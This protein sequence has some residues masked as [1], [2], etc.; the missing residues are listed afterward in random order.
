MLSQ[1]SH[2]IRVQDKPNHPTHAGLAAR[3]AILLCFGI[4]A[5][6]GASYRTDNFVVDAD[7]PEVARRVG[8]AAEKYRAKI[9]RLWLGH[10]LPAWTDPCILEVSESPEAKRGGSSTFFFDNGRVLGQRLQVRGALADL[11]PKVLPHEV[12]HSILAGYFGRPV[13]RW[14]DE[15]TAILSEDEAEKS[16]RDRQM[17]A[18]L[19]SKRGAYALEDL[20]DV[21][22]Y[23]D[24]LRVFYA[25]SYSITRFLIELAD[26]PTFLLFLGSGMRDG[27]DRAVRRHYSFDDVAELEQAWK[28]QLRLAGGTIVAMPVIP[29]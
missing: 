6:L 28:K 18:I 27:W 4:A 9:A 29:Q 22:R 20:F 21:R 14:A 19:D 1:R 13:P 10:D 23:P 11:L 12:T 24:D 2:G 5:S 8:D 16:R 7:S 26:R 3:K 25:Q 17:L 15:G